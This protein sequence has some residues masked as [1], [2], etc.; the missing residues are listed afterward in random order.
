MFAHF[1]LWGTRLQELKEL[2]CCH[3]LLFMAV[4]SLCLTTEG[5][6]DT[7]AGRLMASQMLRS[8]SALWLYCPDVLSDMNHSLLLNLRYETLLA[9]S[10]WNALR[11]LK[12]VGKQVTALPLSNRQPGIARVSACD[13]FGNSAIEHSGFSWE[14]STCEAPA[15]SQAEWTNTH[16]PG[17]A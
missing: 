6:Q 12:H 8:R 7:P 5:F 13:C 16:S 17:A 10:P 1:R 3:R 15:V 14:L 11:R 9:I 4:S 2:S